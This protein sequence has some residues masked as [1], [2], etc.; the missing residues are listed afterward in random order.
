[1][2]V[3]KWVI[4]WVSEGQCE[5]IYADTERLR[6]NVRRPGLLLSSSSG[7]AS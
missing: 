3:Q 7:I 5:H 4:V 1:M 2:C 6:D